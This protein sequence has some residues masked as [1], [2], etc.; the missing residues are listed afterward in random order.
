MP[1]LI[2]P[3]LFIGHGSPMNIIQENAYTKALQRLRLSLPRPEA[4]LVISAHWLTRGTF[5][6]SGEKPKQI[7][8]FDGFPDELYKIQYQPPGAQAVAES[9]AN[10]LGSPAIRLDP[11]WGIDHASWAVLVHLYPQANIPVLELSLDVTKTEEEHFE[12]GKKLSFLRRKNVLIIGSGNIVHNLRRIDFQEDASPYPWAVEFDEFI[13]EAL[14]KNDTNR[15]LH[16]REFSPAGTLA[17][18]TDDH[19]LPM[20]YSAAL[21]E[22]HE[23]IEFFHESFQNASMSMRC[24]TIH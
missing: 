23:I 1:N 16:Y 11:K 17:V 15:L 5:V 12:F 4:I 22:E 18:P 2:M 10:E 14:V 6:C 7:Y 9:L 24:F 13:K 3:V 21:R 19:Y 20:L 8:D